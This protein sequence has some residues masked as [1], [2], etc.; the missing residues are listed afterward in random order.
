MAALTDPTLT[1]RDRF[2]SLHPVKIL[3]LGYLSYVVVGWLLL[4]VPM[5]QADEGVGVLDN[6]FM[7]TSAMSTT[8]L[9]TV[10][11][12]LAYGFG[13]ELVLLILI[14]CGGIGYMTLG[15]FV[16]L[17]GRRKMSAWREGVAAS[18][19]A[20]PEGF[21]PAAFVANVVAFTLI[22]EAI[23]AGLLYW[24]F[25]DADVAG[26]A[27]AGGIGASFAGEGHV[28]WQAIFHSISAFCTAGFSLFPDSLETYPDNVAVNAI[29]SVLSILGAIGFI[30]I[31]D[32]FWNATGRRRHLTLTT[33][34]ILVVTASV[35]LG[36]AALLFFGDPAISALPG[37]RRLLVAWFQSMTAST[38]V[39]FNTHPIGALG[40]ASVLMMYLLMIIGASPSGTGG[41]LKSTSA[42][43]V[44]ATLRSTLRGGDVVT[45]F[46]K[47]IPAARLHAAYATLGFYVLTL[48][49]GGYLLLI[50]E[51]RPVA[52]AALGGEVYPFEDLLFEAASALG[53]VGLSRGVTGDLTPLGKIVIIGL[54]FVGRLGPITFGLALFGGR[55]HVPSD[56]PAAAEEDLAV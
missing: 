39:G 4:C 5:M 2:R 29:V 52:A 41:G 26:R 1:L 17:A 22:V 36:G 12:P 8:G 47:A 28:A 23:G 51:T 10:N 54:M 6:L 24:A 38:T 44:W 48:L 35:I 15:S 11:T 13:G 42:S 56:Q 55:H 7:A 46:G 50:T 33:R 20:L 37:E 34:I 3:L 27:A 21:R 40:L 43:A 49:I 30:V 14:Q 9:V 32:L 18:A 53:T 25:T 45:F 16:V 19:F 31:S